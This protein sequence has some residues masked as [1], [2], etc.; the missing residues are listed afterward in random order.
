V[1]S[2]AA[3]TMNCQGC[4][5]SSASVMKASVASPA[6]AASVLLKP[7]RAPSAPASGPATSWQMAAGTSRRP[8]FVTV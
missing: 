3:A 7:M 5:C 8:A 6:P 4:E 1:P 2:S